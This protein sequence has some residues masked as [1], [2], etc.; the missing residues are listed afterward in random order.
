MSD[1]KIQTTEHYQHFCLFYLISVSRETVPLYAAKS[2]LK[3]CGV[4][5]VFITVKSAF[6]ETWI[7]LSGQ[8]MTALS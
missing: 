2:A 7:S 8:P 1:S 4:M 3:G 6:L 5:L